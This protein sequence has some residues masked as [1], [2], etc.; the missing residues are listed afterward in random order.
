MPRQDNSGGPLITIVIPTRERADTL[1]HTLSTVLSQ[2]SDN[3]EI[4]VSDNFSSDDTAGIVASMADPRLRYINTGKRMSMVGNW[5]FAFHQAHGRYLI[6][7]GD[8]DGMMP[9]AIQ[10]L[11]TL[12]R[13]R[14][15]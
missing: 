1:R 7:L 3:F 9:G 10:R 12:I 4:L 2:K 14:P 15:Y 13:E 8:D 5:E 11:E 6:Y